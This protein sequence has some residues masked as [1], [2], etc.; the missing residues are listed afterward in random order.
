MFKVRCDKQLKSRF[1]ISYSKLIIF[2]YHMNFSELLNLKRIFFFFFQVG[3]ILSKA[4]SSA[5]LVTTQN[6]E[7]TVIPDGVNSTRTLFEICNDAAL[8]RANTNKRKRPSTI[9]RNCSQNEGPLA[10]AAANNLLIA[11]EGQAG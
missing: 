11:P 3:V 7:L 4:N 10:M 9:S 1:L 8:T 5:E 2:G 6:L